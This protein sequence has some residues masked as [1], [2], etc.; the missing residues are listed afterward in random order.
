MPLL[1]PM[2]SHG[3]AGVPCWT[4]HVIPGVLIVK[5]TT[6]GVVCPRLAP[7]EMDVGATDIAAGARTV[8]VTATLTGGTVTEAAE[9]VNVMLVV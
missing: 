1:E 8:N 5:G 7:A 6:A 3:W 4:D 9:A 2:V